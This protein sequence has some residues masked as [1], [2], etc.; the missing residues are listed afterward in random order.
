MGGLQSQKTSIAE[1]KKKA[2]AK[3][4]KLKDITSVAYITP[5]EQLDK[6]WTLKNCLG[7]VSSWCFNKAF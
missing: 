1:Q 6:R 7:A 3:L 2:E 4:S 5:Q